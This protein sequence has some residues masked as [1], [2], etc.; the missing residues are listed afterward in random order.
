MQVP[1]HVS[2]VPQLRSPPPPASQNSG[3]QYGY[4]PQQQTP[5][6]AGGGGYMA[7]PYMNFMADPAAQMGLQMGQ[8]AMKVG[9]DYVEQ[10]VRYPS[11]V[12]HRGR[13]KLTSTSS[14]TAM[15]TSPP[16]NTTSTFPIPTS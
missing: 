7:G 5:N 13:E 10:N 12:L 3:Q 1:Q 4:A 8:S 14:S 9:Q 2:T 11:R 16:S 6:P 15:S